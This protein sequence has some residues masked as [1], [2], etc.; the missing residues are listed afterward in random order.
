[1]ANWIFY[2]THV[3]SYPD[4]LFYVFANCDS[5]VDSGSPLLSPRQSSVLTNGLLVL[6]KTHTDHRGETD[7]LSMGSTFFT[8]LVSS[9]NSLSTLNNCNMFMTV[10]NIVGNDRESIFSI[11]LNQEKRPCQAKNVA[12]NK[13]HWGT[14]HPCLGTLCPEFQL[15]PNSHFL[16][17]GLINSTRGR[18]SLSPCWEFECGKITN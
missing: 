17:I 6:T 3:N 15:F 4:G 8:F 18:H 13:I 10:W 16:E 5:K 2:W 7:R 11:I 1:M 12:I 14:S 9:K